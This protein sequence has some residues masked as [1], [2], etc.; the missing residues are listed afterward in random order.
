MLAA[1]ADKPKMVRILLNYKASTSASDK[2]SRLY[3]VDTYTVHFTTWY[4]V[5]SSMIIECMFV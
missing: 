5:C 4:T 1:A 3:F 2:V